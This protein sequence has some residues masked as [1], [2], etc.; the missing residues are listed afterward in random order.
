M[1]VERG[2]NRRQG[3][4]RHSTSLCRRPI[5]QESFRHGE[6]RPRYQKFLPQYRTELAPAP[7]ALE[8]CACV[9][10]HCSLVPNLLLHK[11]DSVSRLSGHLLLKRKIRGLTRDKET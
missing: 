7:G 9:H 8:L 5:E 10:R 3:R 6:E 11:A 2:W 1:A 4:D